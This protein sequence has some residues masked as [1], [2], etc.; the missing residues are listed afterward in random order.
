MRE[1]QIAF[2]TVSRHKSHPKQCAVFSCVQAMVWLSLFPE[3]RSCVKV[4]VE[5]KGPLSLILRMVSVE[6]KATF[7]EEE[8]SIISQQR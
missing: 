5:V 3:L 4:E 6:G 8:H 7:E 2:R 1:I